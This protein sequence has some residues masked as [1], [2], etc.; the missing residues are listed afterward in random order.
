M[1]RAFGSPDHNGTQERV[2][3]AIKQGVSD[4][5]A[6]E[7]WAGVERDAVRN[8]IK[9]LIYAGEI[10]RGQTGGYFPARRGCLLEECWRGVKA[11]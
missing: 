9:R 6:I 10:R 5:E 11:A 4:Q 7:T 8:A 3:A 1:N 2:L